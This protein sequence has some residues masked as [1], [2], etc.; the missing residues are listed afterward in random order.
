MSQQW[1]VYKNGRQKGPYTFEQLKEQ[2]RS[3]L[4]SSNDLYWTSGMKGWTLGAEIPDL[5]SANKGKTRREGSRRG[6]VVLAV[7][8]VLIVLGGGVWASRNGEAQDL[9]LAD[10]IIG[11]WTLYMENTGVGVYTHL[12]ADGTLHL[13]DGRLGEWMTT[14]HR[15]VEEGSTAYLEFYDE[16]HDVWERF[17]EIRTD[18]HK[19]LHLIYIE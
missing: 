18:G 17:M 2:G 14:E 13:T 10:H 7:M 11:S 9:T 4:V 15:L 12:N 3:G 8:L 6:F 19:E 5:F 16:D 1:Y